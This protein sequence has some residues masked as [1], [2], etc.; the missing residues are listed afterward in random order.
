MAITQSLLDFILNLLRDPEAAQAYHANPEAALASAGHSDLSCADVDAVRPVVLDYASVSMDREYNT[1][2]NH[3]S[4]SGDSAW[5]YSG[6]GHPSGGGHASGGGYDGGGHPG[7][8]H[9]GGGHPGGGHP[10]GG[11]PGGGSGGDDHSHAVAQLTSIV[12]N[13]TYS[14]TIDDR[15]TVTDQSVN[16]NIW[17]DGDV[18]QIFDND[19]IIASGDGAIAAGG[20]VAVDNSTHTSIRDSYNDN[21]DNSV[22]ISDSYNDS[23]DNSDNSTN[24][25]YNDSSD[26]SDN[27]D[28][29]D[30]SVTISDSF[31]DND[32]IDNDGGDNDLVDVDDSGNDS[33]DN[34]TTD[35][36][37]TDNS[38]TSTF[39]ARR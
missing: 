37:T 5:A 33:S 20:S 23:S 31:Q 14:S 13:Y 25:S 16:Q 10:G 35:N 27:S 19:A 38:T 17:A 11:H 24:D 21:S 29:S 12:N 32:G 36:S 39:Q 28:H 9:P 18:T 30:H 26:N 3:S 7:G 15:D 1:G 22:S 4:A 8:G 6:G 34:S 2:G